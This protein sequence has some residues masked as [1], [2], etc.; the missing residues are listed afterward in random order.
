MCSLLHPTWFYIRNTDTS[1]LSFPASSARG[2]WVGSANGRHWQDSREQHRGRSLGTLLWH[3]TL[4]PT[5]AA[6]Q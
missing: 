3:G 1:K 6:S 2:L 4:S 5:Q